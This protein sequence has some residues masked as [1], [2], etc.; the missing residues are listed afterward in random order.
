LGLSLLFACAAFGCANPSYSVPVAPGADSITFIEEITEGPFAYRRDV[1]V[2]ALGRVSVVFVRDTPEG[3]EVAVDRSEYEA[4]VEP[5]LTEIEG[6]LPESCMTWI[7]RCPLLRDEAIGL[8]EDGAIFRG[9][10]RSGVVAPYFWCEPQTVNHE[11]KSVG[12]R[13][14][15][16][17]LDT[18]TVFLVAGYE[19]LE[20]NEGQR[21][22]ERR[23]R[24]HAEHIARAVTL[25]RSEEECIGMTVISNEYGRTFRRFAQAFDAAGGDID[26]LATDLLQRHDLTV[27]E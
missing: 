11:L 25:L 7:E 6:A 10:E 9:G 13:E 1:L 14:F 23:A 3:D 5:A 17:P 18:I 16:D 2:D 26:R 21:S 12:M 15:V 27:W 8:I 22:P 4:R 20:S 24:R 19:A